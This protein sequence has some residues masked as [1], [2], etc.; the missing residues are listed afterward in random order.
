ME[1]W[2]G[3]VA[4]VTG[5]SAGIGLAIA[6]ELIHQ[7]L[8]VVGLARRKDKMLVIL[9]SFFFSSSVCISGIE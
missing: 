3:K 1:R 7:G 4:V 6:K 5:A 2:R 9:Y 8:T